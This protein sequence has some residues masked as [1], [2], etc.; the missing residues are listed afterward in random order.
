MAVILIEDL[1]VETTIGA[2]NW[3][4]AIKQKLYITLAL[5]YDAQAASQ[6]DDLNL[7]IDYA[8]VSQQVQN[9]CDNSQCA[10]LEK[11][12]MDILQLLKTHYPLTKALIKIRKPQA[13]ANAKDLSLTMEQTF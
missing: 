13:I 1:A 8:K 7:A 12:S 2:Y 9:F 10:L 5:H 3:E 6:T 11:L 4:K